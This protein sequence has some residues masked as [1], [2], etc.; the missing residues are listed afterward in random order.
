MKVIPT[1]HRVLIKLEKT[2][3]VTAGG[4]ILPD[5]SKDREQAGSQFAEVMKIGA[6]AWLDQGDGEP[7]AQ[8]GDRVVTVRYPG[9]QYNYDK[10][11]E[12]SL[13]RIINDDEI[14]GVVVDE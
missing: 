3:E 12:E 14:I 4:I 1:G 6:L 10:D 7:W 9:A 2:E 11:S 5:K 8:V 13:Y